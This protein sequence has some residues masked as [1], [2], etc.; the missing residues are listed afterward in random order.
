ML[1]NQ[2]HGLHRF[3]EAQHP[4]DSGFKPPP[5]LTG[6]TVDFTLSHTASAFFFASALRD[7]CFTVLEI[8]NFPQILLWPPSI[9]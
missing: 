1:W 3:P 5:F 8:G 7:S 4:E 6:L 2:G 9:Q